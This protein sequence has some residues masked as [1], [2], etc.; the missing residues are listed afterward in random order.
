VSRCGPCVDATLASFVGIFLMQEKGF[1]VAII[2]LL[3]F[4]IRQES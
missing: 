4:G 3:C 1:G 2:Y